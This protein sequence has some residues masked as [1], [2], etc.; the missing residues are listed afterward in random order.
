M[1][2][3]DE[4]YYKNYEKGMDKFL[5]IDE[6]IE[7]LI[8][9]VIFNIED[10]DSDLIFNEKWYELMDFLEILVDDDFI[11]NELDYVE[12]EKKESF[13]IDGFVRFYYLLWLLYDNLYK[14]GVDCILFYVL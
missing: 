4:F 1:L 14:Y 13:K 8:E 10:D 12:I 11:K 5:N 6:I 7:C 9:E 3:D 2:D